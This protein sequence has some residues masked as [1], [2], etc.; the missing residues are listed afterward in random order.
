MCWG[1]RP[2]SGWCP[3]ADGS[4]WLISRRVD[5]AVL[6][7]PAL[8]TVGV[9]LLA[10]PG[11]AL[12]PLGWL[13]LVLGLDVAHVWAS[14]Y[15][16]YA[17][18]AELRRHPRRYALLPLLAFGVGCAVYATSAALFWTSLAYLAVFHFIRQQ[19]GFLALYRL[20]EGA[21]R[22][23]REA[24]LERAA[25]YALMLWPLLWWH[26]HLPRAFDWFLPGDFVPFVPAWIVPPAGLLAAGLVLAHAAA[27]LRSGRSAPGRDLWLLTTGAVWLGGMVL[28]NGDLA[29]SATNV[30][31]HGLPYLALVAWTGHR[32]WAVSGRGPVEARWFQGAGLALFL[33][34]LLG[35]AFLE[36]AAWDLWVWRERAWL[37]GEA[38]LPDPGW[39]AV[40]LL[41]VPQ[42]THYVLDGLIWKLGP[43]NPGLRVWLAPR[44]NEP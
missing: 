40:P 17:D 30:V 9:A 33:A 22:N 12:G 16:T 13:V 23:T 28:S 21:P 44:P 4:P 36:E 7:A 32:Q 34:P 35:L 37:F 29:F 6:I 18:R 43:D 2:G 11:A 19:V 8:L 20:R 25:L 38:A 39:W 27:R 3:V 1:W 26:A 15:R 24:R 41:S 42:V 10:P 31:L 14:L 5:L